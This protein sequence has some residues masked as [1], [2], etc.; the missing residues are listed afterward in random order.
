MVPTV[1]VV[2]KRRK[3]VRNKTAIPE[4][5]AILSKLAHP[6][7]PAL[8]APEVEQPKQSTR[9]KT[10]Q[11]LDVREACTRYQTI[12]R[13]HVKQ[14]PH[15]YVGMLSVA[16]ESHVA[17]NPAQRAHVAGVVGDHVPGTRDSNVHVE[18]LARQEKTT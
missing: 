16:A 4:R 10:E 17:H 7:E 12:D 13:R 2:K 14:T 1:R 6:R 3:A 9:G 15:F 18:E 5:I 11:S 8:T